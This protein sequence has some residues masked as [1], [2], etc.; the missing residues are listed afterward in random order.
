M[1]RTEYE[2]ELKALYAIAVEQK[3]VRMALEL[4]ER[5]MTMGFDDIRK[6]KEK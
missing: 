6:G 4:L 1:T 3:D 5:S 2:T